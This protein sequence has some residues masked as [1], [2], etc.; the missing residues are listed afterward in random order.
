MEIAMM[1]NRIRSRIGVS[2]RAADA[3][4]TLI[5][6]C[7]RAIDRQRVQGARFFHPQKRPIEIES[8]PRQGSIVAHLQSAELVRVNLG[9]I[10]A[11]NGCYRGAISA[12]REHLDGPGA[13]IRSLAEGKSKVQNRNSKFLLQQA[14]GN[15]ELLLQFPGR[16]LTDHG[17]G[18][19][20]RSES[21]PG[22]VHCV[23]FIPRQ[24]AA[25]QRIL[26]KPNSLL[27]QGTTLAA[28]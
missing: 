28:L 3:L 2:K 27:Q 20:V 1:M 5:H 26:R 15:S 18:Q 19:G 21:D 8:E 14:L 25:G 16:Q 11:R 13:E 12:T 7:A 17:M 23:N 6:W 10:H 4:R 24:D 9:N 22:P